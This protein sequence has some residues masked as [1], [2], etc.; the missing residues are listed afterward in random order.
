M[1]KQ[2]KKKLR[3]CCLCKPHKM[4]KANR[5]KIRELDKLRRA[6]KVCREARFRIVPLSDLCP[7]F[8]HDGLELKD[9][10]CPIRPVLSTQAIATGLRGSHCDRVL[11]DDMNDF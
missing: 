11:F 2:L 1:R 9:I 3:S 5:W 10:K 4:G 6:D 7:E 8:E